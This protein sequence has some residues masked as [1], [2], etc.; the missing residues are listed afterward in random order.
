MAA[1]REETLKVRARR[2]QGQ[3]TSPGQEESN[4]CA[5]RARQLARSVLACMSRGQSSEHDTT[6]LERRGTRRQSII[7]IIIIVIVIVIVHIIIVIA[8]QLS[9]RAK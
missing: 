7:I 3:A 6:P 4:Q 1:R 8:C 5:Q 9:R 2:W